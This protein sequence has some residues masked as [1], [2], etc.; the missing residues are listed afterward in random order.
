MV[1]VV[2]VPRRTGGAPIV[3][4]G[5]AGQ[6]RGRVREDRGLDRAGVGGIVGRSRR[7]R[8]ICACGREHRDEG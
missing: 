7:E 2:F 1:M 5:R 6:G 8:A 4:R 3:G